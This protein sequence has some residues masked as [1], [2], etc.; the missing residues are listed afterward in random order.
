MYTRNQNTY[1]SCVKM[2]KQ[3]STAKT[4]KRIF[5]FFGFDWITLI[6]RTPNELTSQK[7]FFIIQCCVCSFYWL[8]CLSCPPVHNL[9]LAPLAA[10]SLADSSANWTNFSLFILFILC[11]WKLIYCEHFGIFHHSHVVVYAFSAISKW[12]TNGSHCTHKQSIHVISYA[13]QIHKL[14]LS[15]LRELLVWIYLTGRILAINSISKY[16]VRSE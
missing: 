13:N 4:N 10:V 12:F 9:S 16:I 2:E 14:T 7:L 11:I 8:K 6:T 3:T 15:G 5:F 1:L